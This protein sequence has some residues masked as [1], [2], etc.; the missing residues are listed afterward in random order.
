MQGTQA[1]SGEI[2]GSYGVWIM[3]CMINWIYRRLYDDF[4]S[5]LVEKRADLDAVIMKKSLN[6][7]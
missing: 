3:T 5:M 6:F 2:R 1:E 7:S 4:A